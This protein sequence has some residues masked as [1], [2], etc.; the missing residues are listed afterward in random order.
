MQQ[1][2]SD[3]YPGVMLVTTV[4]VNKDKQLYLKQS[5]SDEFYK[6]EI[7][8][9]LVKCHILIVYWPRYFSGSFYSMP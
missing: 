1:H 3:M 4:A 6:F 2:N 8:V 9:V 5:N 7:R